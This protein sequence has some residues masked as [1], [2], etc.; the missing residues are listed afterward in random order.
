M[1]SPHECWLGQRR[2]L[3][4]PPR[5]PRERFGRLRRL[6]SR[7]KPSLPLQRSCRAER[8]TSASVMN[9]STLSIFKILLKIFVRPQ[10]STTKPGYERAL[11]TNATTA[12]VETSVLSLVPFTVCRNLRGKN[13]EATLNGASTLPVAWKC[14][15]SVTQTERACVC[16]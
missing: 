14:A 16:A 9:L 3:R 5:Q 6:W 1:Y 4:T 11:E 10:T 13:W 15:A 2:T 7:T 8:W 12:H